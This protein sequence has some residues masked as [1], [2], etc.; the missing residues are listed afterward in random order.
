MDEMVDGEIRNGKMKPEEGVTVKLNGPN[1]I[2]VCGL[3]NGA[4]APEELSIAQSG[5]CSLRGFPEMPSLIKLDLSN[6][7]LEDGLEHLLGC[8]NLNMLNLS[9]NRFKDLKA[10]EPLKKLTNLKVLHLNGCDLTRSLH[11]RCK[12]A[13]MLP[14]IEYLDSYSRTCVS[15]DGTEESE[16]YFDDDDT[17]QYGPSDDSDGVEGGEEEGKDEDDELDEDD[18]DEEEDDDDDDD[19]EEEDESLS[20]SEEELEAQKDDDDSEEDNEAY[21]DRNRGIKRK[22]DEESEI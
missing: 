4:T 18:D 2:E 22:F 8:P 17:D 19:D 12:V 21:F 15:C 13:E 5:L 20:D 9:G 7:S 16:R 11:Y 6:N 1:G 3:N 14:Q 10:L